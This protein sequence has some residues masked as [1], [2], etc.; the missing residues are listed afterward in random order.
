MESS[1][2]QPDVSHT[3]VQAVLYYPYPYNLYGH[4]RWADLLIQVKLLQTHI[5]CLYPISCETNPY[6]TGLIPTSLIQHSHHNCGSILFL[7]KENCL[8]A[9]GITCYPVL[10]LWILTG[11][12]II[13]DFLKS[14]ISLAGLSHLLSEAAFYLYLSLIFGK[15]LSHI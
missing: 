14:V 1:L 7:S 12:D 15:P 9:F 11:L 3:T 13:S 2:N 6:F 5:S 8:Y 4:S 10:A